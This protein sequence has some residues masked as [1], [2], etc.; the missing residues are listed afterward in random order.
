MNWT[1]PVGLRTGSGNL[2]ALPGSTKQEK[3]TTV[4]P[5]IPMYLP[6]VRQQHLLL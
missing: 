6:G 2:V 3:E 5:Q 1:D 4:K